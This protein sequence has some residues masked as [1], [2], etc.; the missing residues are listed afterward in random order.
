LVVT[1]LPSFLVN[2][3]E[4]QA[5]INL[6]TNFLTNRI[7]EKFKGKYIHDSV[8]EFVIPKKQQVLIIAPHPDDEVIGCS[9]FIQN[10]VEND[11]LI[12]V[13]F[14][15]NENDRSIV[16]PNL[17]N[18]E[19]IRLK[20]A[21]EAKKILKYQNIIFLNY[22]ERGLADEAEKDRLSGQIEEFLIK[23]HF[24]II[25]IPNYNDMHPD[26]RHVCESSFKALLESQIEAEVYLY[27]I[28]GPCL[29][30]RFILLSD[31]KRENKMKA[32]GCYQSQID[33]VD[34][35]KI[36]EHINSIRVN[37]FFGFI[38]NEKY[39]IDHLECFEHINNNY[40]VN[41]IANSSLLKNN[42]Y[43]NS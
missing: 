29:A 36:I 35:F 7:E 27:E 38:E 39:A 22:L 21:R 34:Y 11:C 41:Y 30:N 32:M 40:L 8:Q 26:H 18:N 9:G 6:R 14:I 5:V 10:C 1:A 37:D 16:K 13:V 25:L 20:E 17:V 42:S 31:Q 24:D 3:M 23:N 19:N 12:T 43:I 4:K 33:S 15:T 2:T 28:W